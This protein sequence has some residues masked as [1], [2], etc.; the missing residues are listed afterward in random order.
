DVASL[1]SFIGVDGTNNTLNS[2][3][4]LINLKAKA[5]RDGV[6][7]VMDRLAED[8]HAVPGITF[9]LQP[10][11]DLTI[12]SVLSRAQYQFV[13]QAA[14]SASLNQFVPKLLA[15]LRKVKAI[16]NVSTSFL[17]QGLSAYVNV[18]RNPADRLG[19]PS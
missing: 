1:S 19:V 17:D 7:A 11:Q 8:A 18:D 5:D 14:T 13:L 10:V 12:D 4:M 6:A 16:R 15:E 2:G 3:R 9:Y